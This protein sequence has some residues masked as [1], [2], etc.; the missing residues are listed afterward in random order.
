[1]NRRVRRVDL[2]GCLRAP[3]HRVC[4]KPLPHLHLHL[5]PVDVCYLCG[6]IFTEPKDV[7][8]IELQYDARISPG[9]NAIADRDRGVQGYGDPVARIAALRRNVAANHAHARDAGL[10][11]SLLL[12]SGTALLI[13]LH[14]RSVR[15]RRGVLRRLHVRRCRSVWGGLGF[16]R[17]CGRCACEHQSCRKNR[18]VFFHR[19]LREYRANPRNVRPRSN[20]CRADAKATESRIN[21]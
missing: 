14:W 20:D 13:V 9:L 17:G 2:R 1:M 4:R 7:G 15:R 6:G 21:M 11:G 18:Q 10:L 8:E 3:Q 5:R 12:G 16:L 19:P